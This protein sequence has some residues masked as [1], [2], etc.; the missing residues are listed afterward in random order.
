MKSQFAV[1]NRS[2][3][4]RGPLYSVTSKNHQKR[5]ETKQTSWH[6]QILFYQLINLH[7]ASS[8]ISQTQFH[9][10]FTPDLLCFSRHCA[11][12]IT[13]DVLK[14]YKKNH[15]ATF[16]TGAKRGVFKCMRKSGNNKRER[17]RSICMQR[18]L[19]TVKTI[20]RV[21]DWDVLGLSKNYKYSP[22]TAG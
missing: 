10:L 16:Y 6:E 12:W 22:T 19:S 1:T 14:R 2:L 21:T 9:L 3:C 15:F 5:G 20:L 17:Q 18:N 8:C 11:I 13:I 4:I 7:S